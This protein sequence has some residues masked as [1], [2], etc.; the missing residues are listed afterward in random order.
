MSPLAKLVWLREQGVSARRWVGVK[1]VVVHRLTGA[2]VM[3]HS[4]ASGTGLLDLAALDWDAEALSLAGVE[5]EQLP[6]LVPATHRIGDLVVGAGDGPCANLGIGATEPGIAACSIGTSGALRVTVEEP[7]VTDQTFCYALTPGRWIAGGAI[8]NGGSVLD[9]L[10]RLFAAG[11][12]E[13]LAEAADVATDGLVMHP[14][15]HAERAPQ[16]DARLRAGIEGLT[17]AHTRGHVVRAALEGVCRQLRLVLDSLRD[18]GLRVDEV[19]AT[20]GF[21]RSELWKEILAETLAV[22]VDFTGT[23]D[24]SARG[25][26]LLA[27]AACAD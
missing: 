24:A 22:P 1:E 2:W 20:G 10:T 26:A 8:S 18:A 21:M 11:H 13:L 3:D 27:E 5:P 25:A 14:Y 15:L 12:E 23:F 4:I 17:A 16:W 9:W 7:R 6:Q 19:R